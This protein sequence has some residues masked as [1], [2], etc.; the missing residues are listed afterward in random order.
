MRRDGCVLLAFKPLPG[1]AQSSSGTSLPSSMQYDFMMQNI[2]IHYFLSHVSKFD[3]ARVRVDFKCMP[4]YKC[5][6][7]DI[8]SA[9]LVIF[10][11]C[12]QLEL[13][14]GSG[15]G[16]NGPTSDILRRAMGVAQHHDAV[17]GTSKQHVA[18]DYAKRLAIGAAEC[19]V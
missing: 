4:S 14:N 3:L 2:K 5:G 10:Q 19:Q 9:A 7:L 1:A 11:V 18:D 17:S 6:L 13:I 15:T 8:N 16:K 12:K